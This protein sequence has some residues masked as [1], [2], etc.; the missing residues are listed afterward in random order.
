M[1]RNHPALDRALAHAGAFLDGLEDRP[2]A[3]T[4]TVQTLRARLGKPWPRRVRQRSR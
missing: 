3:A 4:L 2:V 1:T